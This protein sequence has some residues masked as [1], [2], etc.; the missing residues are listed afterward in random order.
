MP[1]RFTKS[2]AKVISN[3]KRQGFVTPIDYLLPETTTGKNGEIRVEF[4]L[5]TAIISVIIF[6]LMVHRWVWHYR[7]VLLRARDALRN[8]WFDTTR[9]NFA[10]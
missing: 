9:V 1:M 4:E 2:N 7:L 6:R 8:Y 5:K 10:K 3:T